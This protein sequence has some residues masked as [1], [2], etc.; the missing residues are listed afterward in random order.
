MTKSPY[1]QVVGTESICF[2]NKAGTDKLGVLYIIDTSMGG[3]YPCVW[4]STTVPL[5]PSTRRHSI[6]QQARA[7]RQRDWLDLNPTVENDYN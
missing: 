5:H 4:Q 6:H 1:E 3:A 7:G 2:I